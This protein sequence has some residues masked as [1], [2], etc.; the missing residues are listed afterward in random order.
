M[1]K[2]KLEV[3]D[4]VEIVWK[5]TLVTIAVDVNYVDTIDPEDLT[6]LITWGKVLKLIEGWV[7]L[8]TRTTVRPGLAEFRVHDIVA[9]PI[10]SI[11]T[12]RVL[13]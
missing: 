13:K 8:A 2:S 6:P 12:F 4:V 3:G 11:E 9:I 10:G 1:P 7:V 5:D